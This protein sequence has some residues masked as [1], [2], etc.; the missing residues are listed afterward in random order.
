MRTKKEYKPISCDYY[1]LLEIA[2]MR[3]T[4]ADVKYRDDSGSTKSVSS[5]IDNLET[6]NKVE[7]LILEGGKEL[8]LDDLISVNG[9]V[10][11]GS[12]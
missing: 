1:D 4:V 5:R 6:R 10:L 9:K 3:K 2:A 8:R 7:Y 11:D 12:C